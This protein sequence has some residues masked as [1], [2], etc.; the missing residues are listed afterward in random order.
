[1]MPADRWKPVRSMVVLGMAR[2]Q[3][4]GS[5]QLGPVGNI[6]GQMAACFQMNHALAHKIYAAADIFLMPSMFEPCGLC[7]R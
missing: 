1:M 5:V 7:A 4:C 3:V 6:P 2:K